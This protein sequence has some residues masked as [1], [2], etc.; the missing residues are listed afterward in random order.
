MSIRSNVGKC[1][2]VLDGITG[3]ASTKYAINQRIGEYAEVID[4]KIDNKNKKIMAS[5]LLKGESHPI[6]VT[7]DG[8]EIIKDDSSASLLIKDASSD[9]EWLNAVL[10]SFV[11]GK[12]WNIPVD[13]I[14]FLDGFIG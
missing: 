13:K 9:K 7:I 5:V 6:E 14:D 4:F 2:K 8:Y 12:S 10:K 1:L 11:I 3:S